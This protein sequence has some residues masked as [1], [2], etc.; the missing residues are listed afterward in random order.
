MLVIGLAGGSGSGKGTAGKIFE[1][2]G[3]LPIDTDKVYHTLTEKMS[4]CLKELVE[5]FGNDVILP[6][7]ALDRARLGEIV[8]ADFEKRERLNRIT[9]Y[10]I[11]NEV[12]ELIAAADENGYFAALVDAP[13]LFESG[14][15]A[16]CDVIISVIADKQT[17]I[18]RIVERDGISEERA[19]VRIQSQ[20]SDEELIARSDYV[21]ENNGDLSELSLRIAEIMNKI[22]SKG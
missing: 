18:K 15:D 10:H 12:R 22:K 6:S 3:I 7:G 17:R 13:L 14:F 5:N 16:E 8:F 4:P 2:Y 20:L 19:V 1:A 9:H 21:L 11:L